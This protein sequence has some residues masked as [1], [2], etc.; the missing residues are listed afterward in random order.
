MI[1]RAEAAES[2]AAEGGE[3]KKVEERHRP[4]N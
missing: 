4:P 3:V 1:H 2:L